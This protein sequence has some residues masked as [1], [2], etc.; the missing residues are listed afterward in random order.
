LGGTTIPKAFIAASSLPLLQF[1]VA[2][3]EHRAETAGRLKFWGALLVVVLIGL[4][5]ESL[6]ESA[7]LLPKWP[8]LVRLV[9]Q[10]WLVDLS[11]KL[12][13]AA[14]IAAIL[15]LVVDGYVKQKLVSEVAREAVDFAVG[16]ALPPQ[17]KEHIQ[18]ILRMPFVRQNVVFT[19]QFA[20]TASGPHGD[21][22]LQV[23]CTTSYDVVNLTDHDIKFTVRTAVQKAHYPGLG[24]NRLCLLQVAGTQRSEAEL[25]VLAEKQDKDRGTTDVLYTSVAAEVLVPHGERNGVPVVT[26]R[27]SYHRRDDDIF[28]DIL[29]PPSLGLTLKV[30]GLRG[31]VVA[32]SFGA[33]QSS[34][35]TYDSGAD[36]RTWDV[37]DVVLPGSHLYLAWHPQQRDKPAVAGG[38]SP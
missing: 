15:A 29:P 26:K 13:D 21:E 17:V 34:A 9:S 30:K 32:A 38:I 5:L 1:V 12:G 37:K 20:A 33:S 35:P 18:H 7:K 23:E 22:Y 2:T 31:Y 25:K 27:I 11:N 8:L 36:E 3:T 6:P 19:Y 24:Q 10:S 28:L 16:Y 14:I 4:A